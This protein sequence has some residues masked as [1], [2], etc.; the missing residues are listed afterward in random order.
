M[1]RTT[2]CSCSTLLCL[3]LCS[4]AVGA[5]SGSLVRNTAVPGTICGGFFSRLCS[6][7]SS[8]TSVLRVLLREDA[9]AAPPGQDQQH[10]ADAE[11]Q[12]H[13]GALKEL[14]QVAPRRRSK[15][16]TISGTIEQRRLPDR[17]APQ[18]PDHDEAQQRH[19]PPSWWP[20]RCRRPTP[21]RSTCG[22]DRPAAARRSSSEVFTR[23]R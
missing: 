5:N 2:L 19:R 9:R 10:H 6:S 8:G 16:T 22:T 15:S 12:R 23:G 4:S 13:P 20:R 11:Q 7:A 17:P 21:A 1:V 18:L 14:E 3:R